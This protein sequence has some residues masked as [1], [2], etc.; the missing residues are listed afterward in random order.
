MS[1]LVQLK[2]GWVWQYTPVILPSGRLRHRNN[3][4]FMAILGYSEYQARHGFIACICLKNKTNKVKRTKAKITKPMQKPQ[5][6][7]W[8]SNA[9][10]Y[11]KVVPALQ[12][13][14]I[15][16]SWGRCTV[17]YWFPKLTCD[18][19]VESK[20]TVTEEQIVSRAG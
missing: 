20:S 13:N 3:H 14:K 1:K 9:Q 6:K 18:F 16:S 2:R 5:Q 19:G 15:M 12:G 10:L 11:T 4:E 8:S 7:P 17:S